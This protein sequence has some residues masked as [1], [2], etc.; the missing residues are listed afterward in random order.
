MDLFSRIWA[1]FP[2]SFSDKDVLLVATGRRAQ[3]DADQAEMPELAA[4][5]P[6][7]LE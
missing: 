5:L 4:K 3:T 1:E 6:L 2:A 7:I